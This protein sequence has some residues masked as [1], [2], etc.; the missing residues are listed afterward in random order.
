MEKSFLQLVAEHI[1]DNYKDSVE[2]LCIVL[3]GKRGALFLKKHLAKAFQKTI[4]VPVI[5]S[6]EDLISALSALHIPDETELV[7][8]LYESYVACQGNEAESFES[9]AKWGQLILHDFNEIDRYLADP[10]KLY[11]NLRDIKEIENWSLGAPELSKQQERYIAFMG[12]L[13]AI[14]KHFKASMLDRQQAWPGLAYRIAAENK[15]INAFG[16]RYEKILFCG[17]NAL[18]TAEIRIF[19]TLFKS[20]K[21]DLLWDADTYYLDNQDQEAGS[22][23]RQNLSTFPSKEARFINSYFKQE[24]KIDIISVPKQLGQGQVVRQVLQD[25][26]SKGV[27][28]DKVAVVLANEKLLWPVLQQLPPEIQHLNITMEYPLRF[29]ASY[30]LIENILEIQQ[31]YSKQSG[32]PSIYHKDLTRLLRQPLFQHYLRGSRARK[33]AVAVVNDLTRRNIAFIRRP[34]ISELFGEDVV[35]VEDLLLPGSAPEIC[36]SLRRL[37]ETLAGFESASDHNDQARLELEHITILLKSFNRLEEVMRLYPHFSEIGAFRQLF[38]QVT[39]GASVPFLGEPL[40]GLQVMGVL[41]TRTLD[42]EHV[43]FVNVNEGVLPSGKTINSFIP[44]DLKRTNGLPLYTEKDAVYAYHFYRLMQRAKTVTITYDSETDTFGKG[45]KSRFVTQL[46]LEASQYNS[47][48]KISERVALFPGLDSN[49]SRA[50]KVEKNAA[51][52][53]KIVMKA[54]SSDKYGALSPSG[55]IM[56][57]ECSLRFFL[58]YGAQLKETEEV[59]ENP[60]AGTFGSILHLSLETLYKPHAGIPL[61]ASTI[62]DLHQLS[63]AAIG[64]SFRT[65]F[66]RDDLSGKSLL[67]LEVIKVYVKK[68]LNQ[69]LAFIKKL[70]ET[71]QTLTILFL[72]HEFS[73]KLQL[74]GTPDSIYIKGKIDRI[75]SFGNMVRV[76]DYKSSVKPTDKFEFKGFDA[77]FEDPGYDKQ[78]QLFI[79]AWLLWK[80]KIAPASQIRPAII[81]FKVFLDEPRYILYDRQ[82]LIFSDQLLEDFESALSDFASRIFDTDRPFVQ[83]ENRDVCQ[84]CAYNVVCNLEP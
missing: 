76:I 11:E 22:F 62:Q 59:E 31:A 54:T 75:D 64:D 16:A 44:N 15:E 51:T 6:A 3:P 33:S 79:Y 18:N 57:K 19:S 37:L 32:S 29:T 84:F 34:Q 45:E 1:R 53:D 83:T 41:E 43:I 55:L 63:E 66:G 81:P 25:L 28:F 69:D 40:Q 5:I 12:S 27:S 7:C 13:G 35:L 9:F 42:F 82:P 71:R 39:S 21:A 80:N 47:Q 72:E 14:Y 77:L 58:R 4:W 26:H 60:E 61:Q 56:F 73:S 48:I 36:R 78:M 20:G 8:H 68:L 46:Q 38:V 2:R 24:K 67:Q 17:F 30:D 52:I 70:G 65:V 23:L 10:S 74:R 49:A 50:L